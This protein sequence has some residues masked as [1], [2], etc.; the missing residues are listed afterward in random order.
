MYD[1]TKKNAIFHS[2][3]QLYTGKYWDI[4]NAFWSYRMCRM[5]MY[6]ENDLCVGFFSD[7]IATRADS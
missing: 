1:M 5:H 4:Q 2:K 7:C 6:V 3:W